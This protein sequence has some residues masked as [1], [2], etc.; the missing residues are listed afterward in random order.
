MTGNDRQDRPTVIAIDGPAAAGKGTLAR[1]LAAHLGNAYLD[2]GAIYRATALKL[3][4]AGSDPNDVAAAIA[5]AKQL[6]PDDLDDER[7]RTDQVGT[8]ASQIAAI[9]EVR[10]ALIAFQRDFAR[11]PPENARGAILDGRDIGTVICPGANKKLFITASEEA[12]ARRRYLELYQR[13]ESRTEAEVLA[14]LQARDQRD[15]ERTVAALQAAADAHLLDTTN[16][17]IE[18]AFA[19]AVEYISAP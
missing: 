6:K 14:E 16:L 5:A 4:L 11:N 8:A 12:R 19:A 3:L 15:R 7:L 10:D 9:P 18:E 2:T 1:R 13:G 17:D